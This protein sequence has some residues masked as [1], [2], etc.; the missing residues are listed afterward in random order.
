M[1]R[2][3]MR[4]SKSTSS[5]NS[6]LRDLVVSEVGSFHVEEEAAHYNVPNLVNVFPT[7]V[8]PDTPAAKALIESINEMSFCRDAFDDWANQMSR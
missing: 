3:P 8:S 2:H 6:L 1:S 4:S 7:D 5:M